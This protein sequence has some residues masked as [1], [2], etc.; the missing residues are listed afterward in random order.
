MRD[1]TK[2]KNYYETIYESDTDDILYEEDSLRA[3]LEKAEKNFENFPIY[4]H[5]LAI[6]Y[7]LRFYVSCT[8]GKGYEE[9]LPDVEKYI[10]VRA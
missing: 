2:T 1:D 7:F 5:C 9:L 8:M 10:K 4:Y 3:M 6:P